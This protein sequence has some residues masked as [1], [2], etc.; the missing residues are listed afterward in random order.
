MTREN[1]DEYVDV[2]R[3]AACVAVTWALAA[4]MCFCAWC[5]LRLWDW[6]A[7]EIARWQWM[8]LP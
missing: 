6:A 7:A 1:W 2:L 8:G 3:V 4:A 5:A